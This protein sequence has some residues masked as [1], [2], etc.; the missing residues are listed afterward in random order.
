MAVSLL[1]A[2]Q[3]GTGLFPEFSSKQDQ[4]IQQVSGVGKKR[5]AEEQKRI[6]Q[7]AADAS[8][9]INV[10]NDRYIALRAQIYRAQAIVD[11]GRSTMDTIKSTILNLRGTAARA[12]EKNAVLKDLRA[13]FDGKVLSINQ[14]ATTAMPGSTLIGSIDRF[15]YEPDKIDYSTGGLTDT[16]LKG[17]YAGGGYR[18]EADDGTVWV[19]DLSVD[20]ISQYGK[21]GG[22]RTKFRLSTGKDMDTTTSTR[23]GMKLVSFDPVTG[24]IAVDVTIEADRPPIAVKGR[25]KRSGIK[26][27]QAWFYDGLETDAGRK[28]ALGDLT[29]AEVELTFTDSSLTMAGLATKADARKIDNKLQELTGKT[30][31]IRVRQMEATQKLQNEKQRQMNAL[32]LR[33]GN[34]QQQQRNYVEAFGA[35]GSDPFF[36]ILI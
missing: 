34:G 22:E 28:R 8:K 2:F 4:L 10:E 20:T 9:T 33:L 23:N 15:T 11:T 30:A 24:D 26:L 36:D 12:A 29:R 3:N 13:E 17:S 25:L 18:I 1:N 16:T 7:D 27:M 6:N 19:P 14:S 35:S 5:I 32:I 21:A 31:A